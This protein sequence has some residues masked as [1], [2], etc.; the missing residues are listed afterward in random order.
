MKK[1][2]QMILDTLERPEIRQ[3]AYGFGTV[4]INAMNFEGV[5]Q[6]LNAK[7]ISVKHSEKMSATRAK[8]IYTHNKYVLGFRHLSGSADR[9]ASIVHESVH[10]IFD[11]EVK[12]LTVRESEA[13]AY[14]AQCLFYY[15]RNRDAL[16]NGNTMTFKDPILKAAW[17]VS[18]LC[19]H[20]S[21]LTDGEMQPLFDAIAAHKLYRDNYDDTDDYDGV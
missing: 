13:A 15:F 18:K 1:M 20:R 19:R 16:A 2:Q 7:K 5:K 3:M 4:Y 14:L 12:P 8:Y 11:V 9:E 6:A 21:M 17:G 10:A